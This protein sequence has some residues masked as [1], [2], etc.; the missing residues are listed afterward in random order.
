MS[1]AKSMGRKAVN[2]NGPSPYKSGITNKDFFAN[3]GIIPCRIA[4]FIVALNPSAY[5]TMA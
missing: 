2:D 4:S 1:I 3:K 5:V